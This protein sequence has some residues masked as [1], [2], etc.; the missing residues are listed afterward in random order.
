MCT[1]TNAVFDPASGDFEFW[2]IDNISW[3]PGDYIFTITGNIGNKSDSTTFTLTLVNPCGTSILSI[4]KPADFVDGE[5]K[6]RDPPFNYLWGHAL[7]KIASNSLDPI[8]CGTYTVTF[9]DNGSNLDPNLF[10]DAS[11]TTNPYQF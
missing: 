1:A 11:A 9:Y 3:P 6:L 7:G 2:T 4:V 8:D 5:Y 10:N